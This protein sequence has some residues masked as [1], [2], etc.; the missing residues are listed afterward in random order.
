M[1]CLLMIMLSGKQVH[2]R[3]AEAVKEEL[4]LTIH[5]S[6]V[7]TDC[8]GIIHSISSRTSISGGML[9]EKFWALQEFGCS[10]QKI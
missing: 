10:N 7:E 5:C 2:Q 4:Q 8:Q 1:F 3:A 9:N 6:G